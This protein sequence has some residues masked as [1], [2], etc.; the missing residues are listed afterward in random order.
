[1]S[2]SAVGVVVAFESFV[3]FMG[4]RHADNRVQPDEEWV[5]ISTSDAEGSRD[6][7]VAGVENDGKLYVAA[8]H[9]LRG[10]YHRAVL[11]ADVEVAIAGQ[12]MSYRAVQVTGEERARIA[13]AYPLPWV[14]RLLTRFPPRSFLR[15][16]PR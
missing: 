7:V 16:D 15:L 4:S 12:R 9:W 5:T 6:A 11:N 13:D 14:L 1:M 2:A 3:L 10:C 8:N